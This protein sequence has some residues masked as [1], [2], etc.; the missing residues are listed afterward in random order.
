M[1]AIH[2]LAF[3]LGASS[4]RAVLGTLDNNKILNLKEVHRF[5]NYPYEKDHHWFWDFEHLFQEIKTGIAKAFA[6]EADIASISI[7]TWGVDY[8]FFRNGKPVRDPFSYRDSRAE[9]DVEK[10]RKI[11]PD[12][13]L[14][15]LNGTQIFSIDT[16]YQLLA[17][18]REFPEDF[19][20]SICLLIPDALIYM[21][22]GEISS[23]YTIASTTGLLDPRR[24]DWNLELFRKAGLP[25][26]IFPSIVMPGTPA[27][28]LR[29]EICKELHVPAV[30]V[31]KTA[32]HDTASAVAACPVH[33]QAEKNSWAYLSSGTWAL[34]GMELEAPDTS[35]EAL[36]YKYTNEGGLNGTIRFLVNIVGT[37][38]L[39]ETRR[40]WNEEGCSLSFAEMEK[41]AAEIQNSP[42]RIDPNSH[43]FITPGNM[44]E[45][46]QR[47]CRVHGQGEIPSKAALVRCIYD[48]L[49]ECFRDN[50]K[51]L[52]Q[53][54]GVQLQT[55]H[56][57]GGA[58]KDN[59]LM[60]LTANA[61]EI[62]I[63]EG[64]VEATAIGNLMVQ[65]IVAG[66][67][68][69][70]QEAR[71]LSGKSFPVKRYRPIA[72]L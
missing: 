51:R 71:I 66:A 8:V 42:F 55:L 6:E 12:K 9:E 45:K 28:R 44:P 54:R 65:L 34:L 14:Y 43:E 47:Y 13:E 5:K 53:I 11:L 68:R 15:A 2:C 39:Q 62:E 3:D 20:N 58:T 63:V 7:D 35:E 64:P 41:M 49:A 61:T 56:I 38:L 57:L 48:S 32:S 1:A 31:V 4:G 24:R 69:N 33:P 50:L 40:V 23:E 37:W 17:H 46:I 72:G 19:E 59:L 29:P 18:Q 26:S 21:L 27:G 67:V 70:L 60:Q 52:Q 25:P 30:K 22:T 36:Q 10:L 16:L